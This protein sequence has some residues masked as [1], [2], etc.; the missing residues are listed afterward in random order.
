MKV[1]IA[2]NDINHRLKL[3]EYLQKQNYEVAESLAQREILE[4]CRSKTPDLIILDSEISG[5]SAIQIIKEI[6]KIGGVSVWNP[7]IL[8]HE[9]KDSELMQQGI[10]AGA[11]DFVL[12]PLD[13]LSL[14]YKVHSAMRHQDLKDQV[15][16]VAH[17]LVMANRALEGV[18][19]NQDQMTGIADTTTFYKQLEEKWYDAKKSKQDLALIIVDIDCFKN[20]NDTYGTD[21]GDEAIKQSSDAL[22]KLIS[23]NNFIARTA[24]ETFAILLPNT[25]EDK[26][27]TLAQ[28]LINAISSLKIEHKTST[29]AKVLTASSGVSITDKDNF[30]SPMDL[31][32]AADYALYQAKHRGRNQ[33][34]F[35]KAVALT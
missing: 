30:K 35:E 3:V 13:L 33:V 4:I 8:M 23:K 26:A 1:L 12:K 28:K 19:M 22:V 9:E 17:G 7:I 29:C 32:E 27:Q 15:F 14:E 10:E 11:D 31:M 34:F 6:R 2:D 25:T 24:G 21:K 18:Q 16:N 5:T 20:Y